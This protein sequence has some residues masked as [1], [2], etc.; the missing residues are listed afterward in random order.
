MQRRGYSFL[1]FL[2]SPIL[3]GIP[4]NRTRLYMLCERSDR[5]KGYENVVLDTPQFA[6]A[7]PPMKTLSHYLEH[8]MPEEDLAK[9]L[10][11]QEM[12]AKPWM[13]VSG[14]LLAMDLVLIS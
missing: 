14:S 2:I 3:I 6:G 1:Q 12:L 7:E 4:N 9:L 10:I 5:F 13:Q 8:Q 11:S